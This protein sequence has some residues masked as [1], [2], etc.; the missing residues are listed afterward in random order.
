MKPEVMLNRHVQI[1]DSLRRLPRKIIQLHGHDNVVNFVLHELCSKNCFNMP[2]AAYFI[3]NPAFNCL[4]GIAGISEEELKSL[5]NIWEDPHQ[6]SDI[7]VKAP[8]NQQVRS[9]T[10]E[11]RKNRGHSHE[12]MAE[13]IAKNLNLNDYGFYAWDLKHDNHGLLVCE[14]SNTHDQ[15]HPHDEILID[16]LSLLSFCP[17]Y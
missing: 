11:S 4:K 14:K 2:K 9:F 7:I 6:V 17:V 10:Y 15:D 1:T 16:G 5:E 12:A 8:F 3:D 13:T